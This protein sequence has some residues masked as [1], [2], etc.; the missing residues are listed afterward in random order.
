MFGKYI[1]H[2]P[3]FSETMGYPGWALREE[4]AFKTCLKGK[5]LKY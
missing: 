4:A 2:L 1:D 3:Y 5:A